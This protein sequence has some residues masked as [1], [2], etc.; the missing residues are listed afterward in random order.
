MRISFGKTTIFFVS[1]LS[2]VAAEAVADEFER[3]ATG[4]THQVKVLRRASMGIEAEMPRDGAYGRALELDRV[5]KYTKAYSVFREA[6]RE[7][8]RLRS[9][10]P[11]DKRIDGWIGKARQQRSL[12]FSIGRASRYA[13]RSRSRRHRSIYRLF[14]QATNAHRKWLAIRAF[15]LRA[16][17]ALALTAVKN[18]RAVLKQRS[19]YPA[20]RLQ[21]AGLLAEL[22]RLME[23]RH[24]FGTARQPF[25][26]S[27]RWAAAYY[28]AVTGERAKALALLA[29]IV[30]KNRWKRRRVHLSNY[31]DVL[32]SDP[33]FQAL[34][35]PHRKP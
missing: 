21:L 4:H 11:R 8:S 34:I 3:L 30:H 6:E 18:Y 32:R 27:A 2:L 19:R 26:H 7:F 22:G 14:N 9:R 25:V 1:I 10:Q 28:Y 16:P 12:S 20:A 24:L 15:G 31:F 23:A 35:D 29:K 33:R 17:R 5:G 13:S